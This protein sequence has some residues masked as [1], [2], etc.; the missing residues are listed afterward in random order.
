MKKLI[1]ILAALLILSTSLGALAVPMTQTD[2]LGPFTFSVPNNLER[3]R[4]GED[5]NPHIDY[6]GANGNTLVFSILPSKNTVPNDAILN[7]I[8]QQSVHSIG[9]DD[10][11]SEPIDIDGNPAMLWYGGYPIA[12][13]S[14]LRAAGLIYLRGL[15]CLL[16]AFYTDNMTDDSMLDYVHKIA[17]TVVYAEPPTVYQTKRIEF[18]INGPYLYHDEGTDYVVLGYDWTNISE[19]PRS[20]D[21]M[22]TAT[23]YQHGREVSDYSPQSFY[24]YNTSDKCLHGYGTRS[25]DIFRIDSLEDEVTI[26]VD[27]GFDVSGKFDDIKLTALPSELPEFD[28][29]PN[30]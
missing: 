7:M 13:N 11:H 18:S 1:A 19:E 24:Q 29:V 2:T 21:Y 20:F 3:V 12:Q 16:V 25:Y 17:D 9:L 5:G 10:P 22:I 14:D 27:D 15:S 8:Y 23:C 26:Y 28:G 6:E 4:S 30:R